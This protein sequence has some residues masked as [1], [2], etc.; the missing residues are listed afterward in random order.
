MYLAKKHKQSNSSSLLTTD[1]TQKKTPKPVKNSEIFPPC[2]YKLREQT[3][4]K[5]QV[6]YFSCNFAFKCVIL[7]MLSI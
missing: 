2:F 1:G 4:E 6:L 3:Q 7:K 5:K